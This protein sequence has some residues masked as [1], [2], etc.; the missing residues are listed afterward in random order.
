MI[1]FSRVTPTNSDRGLL[2]SRE[3]F[4]ISS[5]CFFACHLILD[6]ADGNYQFHGSRHLVCPR[7]LYQL[8]KTSSSSTVLAWHEKQLLLSATFKCLFHAK[9]FRWLSSFFLCWVQGWWIRREIFFNSVIIV[10]L[11]ENAK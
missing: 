8:H 11:E 6:A 4:S 2:L 9:R 1:F 10:N 7:A 5:L 3:L